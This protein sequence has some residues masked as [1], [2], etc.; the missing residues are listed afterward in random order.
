MVG[1]WLTWCIT[2]LIGDI[3]SCISLLRL[4]PTIFSSIGS[5]PWL[6]QW[7][8]SGRLRQRQELDED[9]FEAKVKRMAELQAKVHFGASLSEPHTSGTALR[10]CVCVSMRPYTV[11]LKCA[12]KY[13]PK[14]ELLP[15]CSV[16]SRSGDGSSFWTHGTLL[17]VCHS[18]Y[19]PTINDRPFADRTNLYTAG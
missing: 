6:A 13:F 18:S 5:M 17:L 7:T 12:F 10:R 19:G 11:N 9:D 14:I 3:I 8:I 2:S 4:A 1:G 15:E 16:G